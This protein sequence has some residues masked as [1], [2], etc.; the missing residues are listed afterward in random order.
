MS[1]E[2]FKWDDTHTSKIASVNSFEWLSNNCFNTL[3]IWTF[4]S[5]ISWWTRSILST[6]QDN[7]L[8][9][10][11]TIFLSSIIDIKNLSIWDIS[12]L[13]TNFRSKFVNNSGVS[14]GSSS[15]DFVI[16]SSSTISVEIKWLNSFRFQ[17]SSS[18]RVFSNISSWRNMISG[19]WITKPG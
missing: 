12:G 5:P 19:N 7:C 3:K 2:E 16:A 8:V 4:G 13:R 6:S 17:E 11:F 18:G 9:T 14:K 10:I 1:S 15:H